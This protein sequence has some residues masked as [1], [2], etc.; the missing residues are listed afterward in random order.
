MQ[1]DFNRDFVGEK[2]C[3]HWDSNP[4]LSDLDHL[5]FGVSHPY[6]FFTSLRLSQA[7]DW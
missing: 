5:V 2:C 3:R 6:S 4:G 7:Q 1:V